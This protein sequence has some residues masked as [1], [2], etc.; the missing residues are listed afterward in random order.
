MN[1]E[2]SLA[3]MFPRFTA[4]DA[5]LHSCSVKAGNGDIARIQMLVH[6]SPAR[7]DSMDSRFRGNDGW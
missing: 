7:F 2:T 5:D 4:A 1:A 6:L 3:A